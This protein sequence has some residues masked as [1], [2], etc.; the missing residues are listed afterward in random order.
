MGHAELSQKGLLLVLVAG[1]AAGALSMAIV[2]AIVPLVFVPE[3]LTIQG[4]LDAVLWALWFLVFTVPI[5]MLV[6]V[7]A[8]SILR[9][10][11]LLNPASVCIT[12]LLAGLAT[13]AVMYGIS[14]QSINL[15][16]LVLGGFGGLVS[17]AICSVLIFRRSNYTVDPDARKSSARGSP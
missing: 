15:G 9:N 11:D 16:F 4:L 5:A 8:S 3:E 17:A 10:R 6:G 14:G 2:L 1:A 12:G 7:P 13:I